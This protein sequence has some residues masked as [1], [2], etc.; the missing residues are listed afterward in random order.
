MSEI[1][2]RCKICDWPLAKTREEGCVEDSCSYR[3]PE[4]SSE[5]YRIQERRRSLTPPTQKAT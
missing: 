4:G 5:W 2:K 1:V 3:P